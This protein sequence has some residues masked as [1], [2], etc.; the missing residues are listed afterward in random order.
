MMK[1]TKVKAKVKELKEC[2]RLLNIEVPQEAV[3][4]KFEEVYSHIRKAASIPGFRI[5]HAPEELVRSRY[6]GAAKEEVLKQLIPDSYLA[7][8]EELALI[9]VEPPRI[10]DV[11]FEEG[12]PLSFSANVQVR[13][14]V[15]VKRYKGL[16][17]KKDKTEVSDDEVKKALDILRERYAEFT[18][19]TSRAVEENDFVIA[20]MHIGIGDKTIHKQ[21]KVWLEV[22]KGVDKPGLSENF[23]GMKQG[24][25]KTFEFALGDD[26]D[27][28]EYAGQKATF[29]VTLHEIKTKKLPVLDDNF[30]RSLG[31]YKSLSELEAQVKDDI[32]KTKERSAQAKMEND[33]LD[34]L[35]KA[36]GV[37]LPSILVKRELERL[38]EDAK[39]KLRYQG[40][41]EEDIRKQEEL[42]EERLRPEAERLVR[43]YFILDDI[44]KQ[45]KIVVSDEE[46]KEEMGRLAG[47]SGRPQ[48]EIE[49]YIKRNNLADDIRYELREKKVV[50]FLVDNAII[51]NDK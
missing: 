49:D 15:S 1:T 4:D 19:V 6:S 21:E 27:V 45:E 18:P 13:P 20:D 31:P 8:V 32:L 42:F 5:G 24:G 28:K 9:P 40:Y 12:K 39:L 44:A 46:F 3:R 33:I 11:K 2:A 25:K 26:I 23:I 10:S 34:Q 17:A 14:K 30:A 29:N 50:K 47:R 48:G 35:L 22:K 51:N 16:E 7:A 41:K 37:E 38:I 36:N 43:L